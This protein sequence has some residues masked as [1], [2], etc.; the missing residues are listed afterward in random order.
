MR[1]QYRY[2]LYELIVETPFPCPMLQPAPLNGVTDVVIIDGVVS[3]VLEDRQESDSIL[4]TET[5]A[6]LLLRAGSR[7]GRFLI[8]EGVRVTLERA[9]DVED[10]MLAAF[11]SSWIIAALLRQRGT[12]ILHAS[13]A[14]TQRGAVAFSGL[15]GAGKTTTLAALLEQGC[16]MLADDIT[17]LRFN[18]EGAVVVLP[19][20]SKLNLCEDAAVRMGYDLSKLPRNP[21]LGIKVMAPQNDAMAWEP[22]VLKA[23][24]FLCR[25]AEEEVTC[26]TLRGQE[27]FSALQESMYWALL[28]EQQRGCFKLMTTLINQVSFSR[29]AR[30][31]SRYTVNEVVE[32]ILCG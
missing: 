26:Q 9:S 7:V 16:K 3:G 20:I 12:L 24:Y 23:I 29:I 22:A 11:L 15:P 5:P 1:V 21:R 28:P 13:V 10:E 32:T 14:V 4:W 2:L 19:G 25:H 27:K 6:R 30:P 18:K 8:E 31:E 17:V